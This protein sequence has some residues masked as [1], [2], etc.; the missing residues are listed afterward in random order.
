MA[1]R[2]KRVMDRSRIVEARFVTGTATALAEATKMLWGRN[3]GETGMVVPT[4]VA[5][6]V[7]TVT[8]NSRQ[9]RYCNIDAM[10]SFA[11]SP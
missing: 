5:R 1:P 10:F 7:T 9:N 2:P 8:A 4:S 6:M 3:A 11:I